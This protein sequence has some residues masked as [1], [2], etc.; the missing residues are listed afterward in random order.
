MGFSG[1]QQKKTAK[2]NRIARSLPVV[3]AVGFLVLSQSVFSQGANAPTAPAAQASGRGARQATRI[4]NNSE[5]ETATVEASVQKK[6]ASTAAEASTS[7]RDHIDQDAQVELRKSASP[8]ATP[9]NGVGGV[10][11]GR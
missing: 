10:G 3:M 8:A 4:I 7:N 1:F 6:P 9:V 5:T 2:V 11:G